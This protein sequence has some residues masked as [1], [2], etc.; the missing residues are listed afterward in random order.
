[1]PRILQQTIINT[2][3]DK[4]RIT[5]PKFFEC[6]PGQQL[7]CQLLEDDSLVIH[8]Y[9]NA[10][11]IKLYG[12]MIG[13]TRRLLDNKISWWGIFID[14]NG[15]ILARKRSNSMDYLRKDMSLPDAK[16]RDKLDLA[17]GIGLWEQPILI[18]IGDEYKLPKKAADCVYNIKRQLCE[19]TWPPVNQ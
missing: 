8:V 9:K 7:L 2:T 3:S 12:V 15:N 1:M 18:E 14:G 11:R 6:E 4:R 13:R 19:G 10:P 16:G 17:C 5:L